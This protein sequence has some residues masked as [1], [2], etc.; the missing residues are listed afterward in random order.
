M[1]GGRLLLALRLARP[2]RRRGFCPACGQGLRGGAGAD[3]GIEGAAGALTVAAVLAVAAVAWAVTGWQMLTAPGMT[4]GLGTA[5]SFVTTWAVMMAAMMLPSALPLLYRFARLA[6]GRPSRPA[7][8]AVLGV[9]YLVVWLA[10]GALAYVAYNALGMPW[11]DHA[12]V[13]G[14]ALAL[15]ALYALTPLKRI[16]QD[17]CREVCALHGPLPFNLV[18]AGAVAGWRYGL[19]CLGC[20]AGLMVAMVLVGMTSLGWTIVLAALVL[21]YK[22]GPRATWR[23]DA[24]L[25]AVVA[26]LGILY[27]TLA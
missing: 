15:A 24:A 8:V 3:G 4:M 16:S 19:S 12:L 6:E 10:F 7:A 13:G 2:G 20:S 11:L 27:A 25:A 18:C 23:L 17:R 26:I 5:S 9:I 21:A 1:D 14:V 22:F